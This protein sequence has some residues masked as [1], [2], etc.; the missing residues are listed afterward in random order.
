MNIIMFI[1]S[2]RQKNLKEDLIKPKNKENNKIQ[3]K[4]IMNEKRLQLKKNE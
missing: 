1:E 3:E 2:L 4:K